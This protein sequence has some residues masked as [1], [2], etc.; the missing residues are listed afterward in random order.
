MKLSFD[1]RPY[2]SLKKCF[3]YC[4]I[5]PKDFRIE[6]NQLID[7]GQ[8]KDFFIQ[9]QET[10]CMAEVCNMYFT[11]LLGSN[12]CQ[13]ADKDDYVNVLNCKM[14]DLVHDMVQSNSKFKNHMFERG[15]RSWLP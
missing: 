6:R 2:P 4:S 3:A 9:I 5:F 8:Q 11:I 13:D 14:H 7:F 10:T 1:H 12:L 15:S